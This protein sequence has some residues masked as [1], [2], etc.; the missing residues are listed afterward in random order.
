MLHTQQA[1]MDRK[2]SIG[3]PAKES[4]LTTNEVATTIGM[5]SLGRVLSVLCGR[6]EV[7]YGQQQ[8]AGQQQEEEGCGSRQNQA[9]SS[10]SVLPRPLTVSVINLLWFIIRL[11]RVSF[12]L[13]YRPID[14]VLFDAEAE[15]QQSSGQS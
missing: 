10:S 5:M 9:R 4:T 8:Q 12:D 11:L 13:W 7:T 2:G 6:V 15:V 3:K 14:C 1:M